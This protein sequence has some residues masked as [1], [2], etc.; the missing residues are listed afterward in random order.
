MNRGIESQNPRLD[1]L[2]KTTTKIKQSRIRFIVP[3]ENNG[4]DE[5]IFLSPLQR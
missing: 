2:P 3:P 5:V 4:S 1:E